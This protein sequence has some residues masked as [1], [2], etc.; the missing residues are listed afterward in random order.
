MTVDD[1]GPGVPEELRGR[2][3]E[4]FEQGD[5]VPLHSPGVGIGLTL[6]KRF[7]ELHGGNARV[8][9]REG[10]GSSFH[11]WLPDPGGNA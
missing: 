10:G 1:E 5:D 8:D 7:A 3:F 11:V 6:V 2:V 4:A 9:E